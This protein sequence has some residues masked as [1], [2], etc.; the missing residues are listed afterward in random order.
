[1]SVDTYMLVPI[2]GPVIPTGTDRALYMQVGT[3]PQDQ[4]NHAIASG[5]HADPEVRDPSSSV[6]SGS[7]ALSGNSAKAR[8]AAAAIRVP[9]D[10]ISAGGRGFGF[11]TA[12]GASSDDVIGL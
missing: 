9:L 8:E 4:Y 2:Q 3:G 11:A 7:G 1:M 10:G 6:N 5:T 12:R